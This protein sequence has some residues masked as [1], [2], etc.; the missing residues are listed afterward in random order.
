MDHGP[1]RRFGAYDFD[2]ATGELRRDGV[3]IPLQRQPAR[4][5][6]CLVARAG[7]LVPRADLHAAIW[8][9]DV[10]VDF[11][12][13]LNYCVRQLREVLIDD[14]K[15]PRYIETIARQGY[16]F[17][18]PVDVDEV[19]ATA[20]A[21]AVPGRRRLMAA[22]TLAMVSLVGLFVAHA[23]SG[24]DERHH[25]VTVAIARAIHDAVF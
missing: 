6:A 10:H 1:R 17:V 7:T 25:Q 23:V 24:G 14:A 13:G 4:A 5:L 20:P 8:G 3:P 22:A 21:P 9:Q 18:A 15:A 11:D 16:R 12:R 2:L 19:P